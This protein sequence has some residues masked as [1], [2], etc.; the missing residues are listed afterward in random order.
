MKVIAMVA[1]CPAVTVTDE[2]AST[3]TRREGCEVGASGHA[4]SKI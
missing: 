4:R 3:V 2:A 1:V